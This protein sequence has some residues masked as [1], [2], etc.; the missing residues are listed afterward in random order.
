MITTNEYVIILTVGL[1]LLWIIYKCFISGRQSPR[2]MRFTILLIYA[3]A[4]GAIPALTIGRQ[5]MPKSEE[6][7][8]S[9][10]LIEATDMPVTV[11]ASTIDITPDTTIRP[12]ASIRQEQSSSSSWMSW[13]IMVYLAGVSAMLIWSVMDWCKIMHI[14]L[15]GNKIACQGYVLVTSSRKACTPFSWGRYIVMSKSD[16]DKPNRH[17]ILAH[18]N[19]HIALHHWVDLLLAQMAIVLN[20]FNPAAWLLRNELRLTH[21]YQADAGIADT[22]ISTYDYQ[23]FLINRAAGRRLASLADS[24][25]HSNLSKRITMMMKKSNQ[26]SGLWRIAVLLPAT[27]GSAI[28][29]SSSAMAGIIQSTEVAASSMVSTMNSIDKSNQ[30]IP[31]LVPTN[32]PG[33]DNVTICHDDTLSKADDKGKTVVTT[34]HKSASDSSKLK[35]TEITIVS[36]SDGKPSRKHTVDGKMKAWS[37]KKINANNNQ[38]VDDN[39]YIALR[40]STGTR[41]NRIGSKIDGMISIGGVLPTDSIWLHG[42][43]TSIMVLDSI[44]ATDLVH[45]EIIKGDGDMLVTLE[46][47]GIIYRVDGKDVSQAEYVAAKK[48]GHKTESVSVSVTTQNGKTRK[49]ETYELTTK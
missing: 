16:Y 48:K 5:L 31:L 19:V 24:L 42:R 9:A 30:K 41:F 46:N 49:T 22:G 39:N 33:F 38:S 23:M 36:D 21:E 27:L 3:L 45:V 6:S 1:T 26:K 2:A 10:I 11:T 35:S 14:I 32:L 37:D 15:S 20:W 25:N 8:T 40:D 28:L 12:I 17:I 18:E 47:A 34:A 4:L 44:L 7:D 29:L 13:A 43:K